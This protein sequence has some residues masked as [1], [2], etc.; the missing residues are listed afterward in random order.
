MAHTPHRL[1]SDTDAGSQ[2]R[3]AALQ[4]VIQHQ[5]TQLGIGDAPEYM[6]VPD[7]L[8]YR[9]ARQGICHLP[10][11]GGTPGLPM[12]PRMLADNMIHRYRLPRNRGTRGE[13]QALIARRVQEISNGRSTPQDDN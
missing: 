13:Y 6:S 10:G 5:L 4:A 2:L 7:A 8:A 11:H 1:Y 3:S 9:L 12:H